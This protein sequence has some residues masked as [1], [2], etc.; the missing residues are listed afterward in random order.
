M[1]KKTFSVKIYYSTFITKLVEADNE[2]EAIKIARG[3]SLDKKDELLSNL[4][5]WE[6]ADTL[7]ET[8]RYEDSPK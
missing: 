5:P 4:E 7:E 2:L 1:S 6:E 8:E 3:Q